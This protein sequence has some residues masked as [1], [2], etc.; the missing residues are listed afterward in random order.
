MDYVRRAW[1]AVSLAIVLAGCAA[2]PD[3]GDVEGDIK[4]YAYQNKPRLEALSSLVPAGNPYDP[5][6]MALP[7]TV[8]SGG[9]V[10]ASSD[11][12]WRIPAGC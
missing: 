9:A 3:G 6:L 2:L 8:G 1:P 7:F 10:I 12:P 4:K 5:G 11:F